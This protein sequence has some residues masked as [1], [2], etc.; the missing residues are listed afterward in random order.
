MGREVLPQDKDYI[1][2]ILDDVFFYIKQGSKYFITKR[3]SFVDRMFHMMN[4]LLSWNLFLFP[5]FRVWH[6]IYQGYLA[7]NVG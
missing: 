7:Y 3:L 1:L 6:K 2:D 4:S 5:V